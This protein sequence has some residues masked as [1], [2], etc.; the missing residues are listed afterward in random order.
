MNPNALLVEQAKV[1]PC[2]L[3]TV[4]STSTPTRVSLKNYGKVT[5]LVFVKNATTVTGSAITLKQSKTVAG[6]S[7]KAVSFARAHRNIDT[8]AGDT[9][10]EF[11]VTSDTFTTDATNSKN[12]LYVLEVRPDDLDVDGGFDVVGVGT[13]DATAATVT[14]IALLWPARHGGALD[15]SAI[16]D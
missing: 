2:L 12:L 4:P 3:G 6:G 9:L 14:V 11:A 8:A 16:T 13:G 5:F 10:A 15:A 1:V 7:E